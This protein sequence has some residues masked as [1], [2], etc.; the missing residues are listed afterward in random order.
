MVLFIVVFL[1]A[2]TRHGHHMDGEGGQGRHPGT[3]EGTRKVME[4]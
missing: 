1:T 3:E 2:G 4:A